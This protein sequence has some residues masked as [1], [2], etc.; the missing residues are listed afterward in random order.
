M[1]SRPNRYRSLLNGALRYADGV[2]DSRRRAWIGVRED[3][4]AS[5]H[6]P[7]NTIVRID[8][9]ASQPDGGC[10]LASGHDFYSSPR[11]SPD[12][13]WLAYLAW[14][15][16]RMPWVGTTLYALRLD[17]RRHA[18][19]QSDGDCGRRKES[20]FQPEWAPEGGTCFSFRTA[21]AGGISIGVHWTRMKIE[22]LAPMEAEFGQPQWV[23]GM[24]TYAFAGA[25]RLVCSYDVERAGASRQHRAGFRP[26][27]SSSNSPTPISRRC[28]PRETGWFS[29]PAR[30]QSPASFVPAGSGR[31][32]RPRL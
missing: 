20:V 13:R 30:P 1:M 19:R 8:L 15:H 28:A 27:H 14:D 12:G 17:P 22:A 16:P 23:F 9:R 6:E 26:V 3:H 25:G 31:P 7:A 18:G 24:S 4:T 29:A 5:G 32:E 11:L 10:V 21:P 2:I